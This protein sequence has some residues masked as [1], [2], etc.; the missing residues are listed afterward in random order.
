MSGSRKWILYLYQTK[1][2]KRK[3]LIQSGDSRSSENKIG[4]RSVAHSDI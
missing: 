4:N 3:L 2:D 1:H